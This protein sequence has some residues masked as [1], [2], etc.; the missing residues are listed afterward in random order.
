MSLLAMICAFLVG[1]KL[2]LVFAHSLGILVVCLVLLCGKSLLS[3]NPTILCCNTS[4]C[5][6]SEV[7]HFDKC[8]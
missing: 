8:P 5:S 7:T 4:Q 6:Y 1:E 3:A 2:H